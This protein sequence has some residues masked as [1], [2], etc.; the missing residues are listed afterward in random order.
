MR[1]QACNAELNDY[2]STRKDDN[3]QF[4]DFCSDCFSEVKV[5]LWERKVTVG[6]VIENLSI[7]D[8]EDL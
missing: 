5:A 6:E 1:C 4:I 8:L 7:D 3:G 2:E